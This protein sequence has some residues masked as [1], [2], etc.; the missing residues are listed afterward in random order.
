MQ[1]SYATM[2]ASFAIWLVAGDRYGLLV[3][4]AVVMGVAYGGF[5]ALAPAVTA[6]LFGTIG[7]GGVLGALYTAAGLGGLVG[8][9]LIG[10]LI[11]RTSYAAGIAAAMAVSAAAAVVLRMLP[12]EPGRRVRLGCDDERG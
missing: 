4:F 12:A 9:P 11:D 8:P 6:G 5:I 10:A 7:L 1:L 3:L 2:A